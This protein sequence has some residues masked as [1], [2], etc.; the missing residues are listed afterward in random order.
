MCIRD[1]YL[2]DQS[3]AGPHYD[4]TIAL[5]MF[6]KRGLESCS[7]E[8]VRDEGCSP[9]LAST[10]TSRLVSPQC[11]AKLQ[12]ILVSWRH[13]RSFPFILYICIHVCV[14][15]RARTQFIF[16]RN[17]RKYQVSLFL[18]RIEYLHNASNYHT[19]KRL[20][21]HILRRVSTS[22]PLRV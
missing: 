13:H 8:V 4:Y 3:A 6:L 21:K 2:T 5:E 16:K 17:I 15:V 11:D 18:I 14:C 22:S 20:W 9:C 19:F 12:S 7:W 10:L 1:R